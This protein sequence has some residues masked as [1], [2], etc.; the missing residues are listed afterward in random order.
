ML[1]VLKNQGEPNTRDVAQQLLGQEIWV[2]WPHMVEAKVFEVLDAEQTFVLK[3][4]DNSEDISK[5]FWGFNFKALKLIFVAGN[6]SQQPQVMSIRHDDDKKVQFSLQVKGIT[7]RYKSRWGVEIGSTKVV[8]M[9]CPMTG[10]KVVNFCH[11]TWT[12]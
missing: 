11:E 10:R 7:E 2:S 8:L 12:S 4:G 9:A 3:N 1:L 5:F 6:P